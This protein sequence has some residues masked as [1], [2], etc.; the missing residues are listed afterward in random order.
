MGVGQP[1]PLARQA[2]EMRCGDP[3][4]GVE[5]ADIAVAEIVGEDQDDVG[6]GLRGGAGDGDDGEE[7]DSR[8]PAH[9]RILH[10]SVAAIN[11]STASREFPGVAAAGP[12]QS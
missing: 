2:I 1:Q 4:G 7:D 12:C 11:R 9:A 8:E 6:A 10:G 5:R 3:P